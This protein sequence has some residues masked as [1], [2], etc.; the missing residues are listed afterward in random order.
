MGRCGAIETWQSAGYWE[1]AFKIKNKVKLS[2][3][4]PDA[5]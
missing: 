4:F 3:Y 5:A 1:T 2:G